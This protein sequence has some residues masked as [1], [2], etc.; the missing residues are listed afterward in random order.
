MRDI[1]RAA[2]G[3]NIFTGVQKAKPKL[4]FFAKYKLKKRQLTG[5]EQI[6]RI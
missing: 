3:T 2:V 5:K 1:S 4:P 6:I